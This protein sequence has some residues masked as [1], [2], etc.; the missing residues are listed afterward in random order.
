MKEL[1][2]DIMPKYKNIKKL[3]QMLCLANDILII[4]NINIPDIPEFKDLD[5]IDKY[6]SS[7]SEEELDILSDGE[8]QEQ[9]LIIAKGGDIAKNTDTLLTFLFENL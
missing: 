6:V 3:I 2:I 1:L 4:S 5:G 9:E 7:L 8:R